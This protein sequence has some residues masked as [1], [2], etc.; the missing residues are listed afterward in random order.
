MYLLT[1][2]TFF[3][4]CSGNELRQHHYKHS[5]LTDQPLKPHRTC[6]LTWLEHVDIETSSDAAEARDYVTIEIVVEREDSIL[7]MFAKKLLFGSVYGR[8]DEVSKNVQ[9]HVSK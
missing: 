9:K 6:L 1:F 3:T 8:S 4:T 7:G 2:L 5:R